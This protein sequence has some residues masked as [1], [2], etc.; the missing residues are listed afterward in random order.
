MKIYS[1]FPQ[2][3]HCILFPRTFF[4]QLS[5]ARCEK[6]CEKQLGETA[7][8]PNFTTSLP[9]NLLAMTSLVQTSLARIN[10]APVLIQN[11][12]IAVCD[13][14]LKGRSHPADSHS[15]YKDLRSLTDAMRGLKELHPECFLQLIR[16]S[17]DRA[18]HGAALLY[19][20]WSDQGGTYAGYLIL[21]DRVYADAPILRATPITAKGRH[22]GHWQEGTAWEHLYDFRRAA[23]LQETSKPSLGG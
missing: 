21:E 1:Y 5:Q 12:A 9:S 15:L 18:T 10:A 14:F 22:G 3:P 6:N 17:E 8:L 4:D 16:A 7:M 19:D 23:D 13:A 20:L 2:G 11:E